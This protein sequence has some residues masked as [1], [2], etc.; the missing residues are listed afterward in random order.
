MSYRFVDPPVDLYSDLCLVDKP[1]RYVGGEFG[2]IAPDV[3][4]PLRIAVCFP[5]LYE[6]GMSNVA[7]RVMYRLFNAVEG[8]SCE[9]VFVP[10]PDFE[11]VLRDRRMPLYSLESGT[12]LDQFDIIAVSIGYEL[13][14]TNL[15]CLLDLGGVPIRSADRGKAHTIV[16]AGGPAVTNPAPW[17]P[18]V[19]GVFV[20]E[21]E[22]SFSV[23]LSSLVSIRRGGGGRASL[24]GRIREHPAVWYQGSERVARADKWS[25]FG[26]EADPSLIAVPGMR[27]VHDHGTVE[28]MRGCPN[29]CRFCHAGIYYRPFR[30]KPMNIVIEEVEQLVSFSGYREVTLSSLSSG[31]Y[32]NI[33]AVIR[34]LNSRFGERGVSFSLPSLRIDSFTL[35][36][37]SE[38]S[39]LRKSGLTFA[40]E[41]PITEWQRGINKEVGLEKTIDIVKAAKQ[42]GWKS[43]KFY[44]MLG[45]P[46]T[47]GEDE[48]DAIAEFVTSV[49]RESGVQIN[50]NVTTFVPKPHTPFQWSAQLTE[51]EAIGRI[52]RLKSFFRKKPVDLRYG[53]PFTS[54][55]EGLISRGSTETADLVEE[56]Y[57]RGARLDAWEEHA[58]V[59]IWRDVLDSKSN[60]LRVNKGYAL[61]DV[62]PWESVHLGVNKRFLRR[63]LE[64]AM[65][66]VRTMPCD[67]VC[68][69]HCGV[70]GPEVGVRRSDDASDSSDTENG[71]NDE[72]VD[73]PAD[74][75]SITDAPWVMDFAFEKKGPAVFLAHLDVTRVLERACMRAGL[76]VRYSRGFN[77]KPKIEF[78]HPLTLGIE[79]TEEI[80]RIL[81]EQPYEVEDFIESMNKHLHHGIRIV[82]G[83]AYRRKSRKE[84]P[85]LMSVFWG[86]RY[87]L[88]GRIKDLEYISGCIE[89][90]I[91]DADI[92][93]FVAIEAPGR[94]PGV[95]GEG[96]RSALELVLQSVGK[97]SGLKSILSSFGEW[98]DVLS[99]MRIT[100]CASYRRGDEDEPISFV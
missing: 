38:V 76:R 51:E 13:S 46:V 3:D 30:E 39:A 37:L 71:A 18:F 32:R 62:L 7:I 53:G 47:T 99:M 86:A 77:P 64:R 60:V 1:A 5:D 90:Y 54:V 14:A 81:F 88:S 2:S 94:E 57:R 72:R 11:Q 74:E 9:R 17:E 4:A 23:L 25:D 98:R 27:V 89:K 95:E 84:L 73:S 26:L 92:S 93:M 41:T 16:I 67:A 6:I 52:Q 8:V 20:G 58:S 70:C 56:A 22:Q 48:S 69:G 44:F 42:R 45:L 83:K 10:A 21:V 50:V 49:Q 65:N 78:A 85:S 55:L 35:P 15:L 100:R 36:L 63:E 61:D 29:G 33:A 31:D 19:D 66:G 80:A 34:E 87:R 59:D 75:N 12:P 96:T 24:L 91:Q 40:V 79:S 28:I 97:K 82:R 43:A 68:P